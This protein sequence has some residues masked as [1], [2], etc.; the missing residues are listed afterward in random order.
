DHHGGWPHRRRS[1]RFAAR[2]ARIDADGV[3]HTIEYGVG[4]PPNE[5]TNDSTWRSIEPSKSNAVPRSAARL[6]A[7]QRTSAAA[8]RT[9]ASVAAR[10]YV[11]NRSSWTK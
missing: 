3:R 8:P 7:S 10:R 11:V 9:S 4:T 5:R 1:V 6:I 2:A